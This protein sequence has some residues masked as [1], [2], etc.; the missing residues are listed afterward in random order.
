MD[1]SVRIKANFIRVRKRWRLHQSTIMTPRGTP[2]FNSW[3]LIRH[4]WSFDRA[5]HEITTSSTHTTTQGTLVTATSSASESTP[6]SIA[7]APRRGNEAS[8]CSKW[9]TVHHE[10]SCNSLAKKHSIKLD[11]FH[12]WSSKVDKTCEFGFWSGH[13]YCVGT[14]TARY[15]TT[16][17][18]CYRTF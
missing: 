6:A 18:E 14:S 17:L 13:A 11:E 1:D 15:I 2:R 12:G 8:D 4:G 16:R 3:F 7:S 5:K 9:Y 10:D